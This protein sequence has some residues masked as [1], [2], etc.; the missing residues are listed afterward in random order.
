MAAS[1]AKPMTPRFPIPARAGIHTSGS[2]SPS[3]M[4]S[5]GP[6]SPAGSDI[7]QP[8]AASA[9]RRR[10]SEN[11]ASTGASSQ[12]MSTPAAAATD[13]KR[14]AVSV[15]KASGSSGDRANRSR[16]RSTPG[17][18]PA[19]AYPVLDQVQHRPRLLQQHPA[20]V[21]QPHAATP[22]DQQRGAHHL[23]QPP[24][25]LAQRR[26]GDEDPLRRPRERAGIGD[27]HQVAQM[28]Q[29]D[30]FMPVDRCWRPL[31]AP[32]ALAHSESPHSVVRDSRSFAG[33]L[34]CPADKTSLRS[35][36]S[37]GIGQST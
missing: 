5:S 31:V 32:S 12:V 25:L 27:R 11:P 20:R 26:L 15:A 3:V 7:T 36:R 24:D 13:C 21:G 33:R 19:A 4:T 10:I 16:G 35:G 34:W 8:R 30:S 18:L 14:A 37:P 9:C 2:N 22:A 17:R 23:L 6:G 1:S 29:L 28:P